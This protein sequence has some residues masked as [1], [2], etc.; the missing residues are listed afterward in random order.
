MAATLQAVVSLNSSQFTKGIGS[1]KQAAGNAAGALSLAFG[2]ATAELLAMQKAFGGIGLAVGVMKQATQVGGEFEQQM[3]NVNSVTDLTAEEMKKVEEA[4]RDLAK[5]TKFTAGEAGDALYSLAS[6]GIGAADELVNTLDPALKLA[7]ATASDTGA[8]AELLTS[9]MAQYGKESEEA[10]RI[11]DIFAGAVAKSPATMDR[12]TEAMKHAGPTASAL[13]VSLED[14]VGA[15]AALATA[16][17]KGE[18]GG[19]AFRNALLELNKTAEEGKTAVGQALKGWSAETDGLAGAVDMLNAKNI[20]ATDII[21]D[22]GKRAGPAVAAAMQLGGDAIRDM[23]KAVSES[24]DVNEMYATQLD[25]VEGKMAILTS[26]MQENFI[27][28]FEAAKPVLKDVIAE[29]TSLAEWL[30]KLFEMLAKG[31]F[32]GAFDEMKNAMKGIFTDMEAAGKSVMDTLIALWGNRD[33]WVDALDK[34]GSAAGTVWDNILAE[35]LVLVNGIK[36]RI[37]DV[38]WKVLWDNLTSAWKLMAPELLAVVKKTVDGMWKSFDKFMT[39]LVGEKRWVDFQDIVKQTWDT[40]L[41]TVVNIFNEIKGRVEWWV[42]WFK[43]D[44]FGS[45]LAETVKTFWDGIVIAVEAAV[46]FIRQAWET[47]IEWAGSDTIWINV[48]A[49]FDKMVGAIKSAWN[50][51]IDA[52]AAK[53]VGFVDK[54]EKVWNKV[55][56]LFGKLFGGGEANADLNGT[57][58]LKSTGPDGFATQKTAAASNNYLDSIAVNTDHLSNLATEETLAGLRQDVKNIEGITWE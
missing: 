47:F 52:I 15:V 31:D 33:T 16:G 3:A 10:G 24:T 7:G 44:V 11:A 12:L 18:Q 14:T 4:T 1:I 53:L 51:M 27:K 42:N 26:T 35:A 17:F 30:G 43:T 23:T 13:G 37:T 48:L 55:K 36:K 9:T 8:A 49:G 45:A 6:A 58:T 50:K 56:G 34:I 38:K 28:V 41:G 21:D 2:G 46:Y 19:T 5:T 57:V 22:L 20:D 39:D 32:A 29:I 40:I 54:V 25:T